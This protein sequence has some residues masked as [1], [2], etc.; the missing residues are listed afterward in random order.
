MRLDGDHATARADEMGKRD[1]IFS[2]AGPHIDDHISCPGTI[3]LEPK[4]ACVGGQPLHL[5]LP[6]PEIAVV[7][8]E[9]G[10]IRK[11]ISTRSMC[12]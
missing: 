12:P 9:L 11:K 8:V 5:A 6:G 1:R 2:T 7:I 4:I 3:M 10:A